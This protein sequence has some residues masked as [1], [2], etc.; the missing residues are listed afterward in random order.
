[1]GTHSKNIV[2][3]GL[4]YSIDAGSKRSYPGTGSTVT[5]IM[6]KGRSGV[7]YSDGVSYS[8]DKG[9]YFLTDGGASGISIPD[10]VGDQL[11]GQAEA[12]VEMFIIGKTRTAVGDSGLIQLSGYNSGNGNLY[13][14]NNGNTYIDIFRTTRYTGAP[15]PNWV[16]PTKWHQFVVTS[17]AGTDGYKIFFNGTLWR[18]SY[19]Y[20][21]VVDKSIGAGLS[22]GRNSS[23]RYLD[24]GIGEVRIYNKAL[25]DEEVMSNYKASINRYK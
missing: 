8:T 24:G 14:Y 23:V 19:G 20:N 11:D 10:S 18:Q 6:D 13:F 21:V 12:S 4:I 2:T 5:D 16:D 3:D 15:S 22:V 1:M 9:G 17:K 25:T 7:F